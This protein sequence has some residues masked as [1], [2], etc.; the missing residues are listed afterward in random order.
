MTEENEN[1]MGLTEEE[2]ETLA[3]KVFTNVIEQMTVL[4]G[5][6]INNVPIERILKA[7]GMFFD[8][9]LKRII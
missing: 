7:A 6:D 4:N 3:L 8:V 2:I 1:K 5:L 9:P